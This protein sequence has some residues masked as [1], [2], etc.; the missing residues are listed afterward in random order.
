MSTS[1]SIS[2]AALFADDSN[3]VVWKKYCTLLPDFKVLLRTTQYYQLLLRA[4]QPMG[5]KHNGTTT[6]RFDS[7]NTWDVIYIARTFL[8]KM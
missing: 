7:R 3:K 6:F 8:R 2:H 1:H 4:G 5:A